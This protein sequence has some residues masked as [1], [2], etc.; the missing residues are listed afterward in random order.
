[1]G[2]PLYFCYFV[3]WLF[4]ALRVFMSFTIIYFYEKVI[5]SSCCILYTLTVLIVLIQLRKERCHDFD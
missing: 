1:M 5:D 4:F 2:A 3:R